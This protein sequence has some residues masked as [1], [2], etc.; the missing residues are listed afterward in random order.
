[1]RIIRRPLSASLVAVLL[2]TCAAAAYAQQVQDQIP[3]DA[4]V[5]MKVR[6]LS[7]TST[8]LGKFLTD[9][10]LAAMVPGMNDPLAFTQK[11]LN[12]SQG[13]RNDGDFAVVYRDPQA[14]G[15]DP[16]KS[17]VMLIPVSDY[18]SFL[19]NFPDAKTD[20]EVSE[21]TMHKSGEPGFVAHWGNF[22]ALSPSKMAISKARCR[23]ING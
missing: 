6:N 10:G 20:G 16:E 19:A 23:A 3:N 7:A 15:E 22:A 1:M 4:L 12:I 21:V 14:S 13:L 18:K 17:I 9:L 5:V 2:L 8:K 11:Q